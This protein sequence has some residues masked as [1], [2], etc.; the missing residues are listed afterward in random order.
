MTNNLKPAIKWVG[1]KRQL[2]KELNKLKPTSY[3]RYFEPFVGAGAFLFD[4]QP[5]NFI[6]NDKNAELINM[7]QIIKT[8]PYE[9]ISELK[10]HQKLNSKEHFLN[11][12]ALD[13]DKEKFESLSSVTKAARLIYMLKV[14]FNGLYRV[15][16]KNQF[17]APYGQYVNPMI[18][19]ELNILTISE[20]LN[21]TDN[22][23]LNVDF[24]K[25]LSSVK[26]HDFVYLD[27]PYIPLTKTQ[28]FVSYTKDGF[29]MLD[30]VRLRDVMLELTHK[31]AYVMLSNSATSETYELFKEFNIHEVLAKRSI[32]CNG[33][34]RK[35][36]KELIIKKT[37]NHVFFVFCTKIYYIHKLIF[38]HK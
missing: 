26:L 8:K 18:C 2:L 29:T 20:F 19:N 32:N 17:N 28:S 36:I 21:K 24:Q 11:V 6:I 14:D 5:T 25:A 37:L 13:R 22:L 12:R 9:L 23:I 3:N 31:G 7:Y 10:K 35:K 33:T 30:H 16:S 34:K 27:P 4:L 38:S 15:N 1:G